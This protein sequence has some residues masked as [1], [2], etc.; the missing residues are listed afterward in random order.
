MRRKIK[1]KSIRVFKFWAIICVLILS[2][3]VV[4]CEVFAKGK[5]SRVSISSAGV[6]G[7]NGSWEPSIS[8]DG[9]YVAFHSEADNLVAGDTNGINDIF[10]HDRQTGETS[11]VSISSTS[12]QGNNYS[13]V[14]SISSDGRFVTFHSFADNLVAGDTNGEDDIFVHDRQTGETSRVSISSAGVQGNNG[15][16]VSSIS[17]DGRFVAFY[18][19]ADNLVAGD[20][21]G[22]N[23]IFVHD[24]LPESVDHSLPCIPC[25]QLLLLGD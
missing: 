6:Q 4:P 16:K 18:S 10:V 14:A 11:R 20:T 13:W 23:D 17:S 1:L 12:V 22:I 2:P 3:L 8:S 25:I 9:R 15:S 21:N 24:R 7:N 19:W 5:T